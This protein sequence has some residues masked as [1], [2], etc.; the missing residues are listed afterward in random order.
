MEKINGQTAKTALSLT[1]QAMYNQL[2]RLS[3]GSV[4]ELY[5]TYRKT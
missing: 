4:S 3:T 1:Q 5:Y 2:E